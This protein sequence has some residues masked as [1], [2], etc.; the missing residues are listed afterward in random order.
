V[1]IKIS[2]SAV[3]FDMDG[4]LVDST[5]AVARVWAKWAIQHGFEPHEV[6]AKAHGRPSITTVRELLPNADHEAENRLVERAEIEDLEGVVPIP[7]ANELLAALPGNR[8][9]IVT[10][11]TKPLADAR[12]R[13]VGLKLPA[14]VVTSSDIVNG[15]PHPEPYLTAAAKLGFPA[16]DCIVVED[17]PAGIRA[18][19]A[20][21]SRVIALRTTVTD[22]ELSAAGADWFLDNCEQIAARQEAGRLCLFLDE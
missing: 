19:K 18:G 6:V 11:S 13:F 22:T 16:E 2:C 7:G 1:A 9:A 14:C 5:P 15:K 17:A 10:S 3:L 8:W 12:L 4:V 20:A 21:G